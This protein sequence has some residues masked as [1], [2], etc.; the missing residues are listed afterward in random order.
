[1][2]PCAKIG[3]YFERCKQYNKKVAPL[4][5]AEAQ[6]IEFNSNIYFRPFVIPEQIDGMPGVSE[7]YAAH[8]V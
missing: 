6:D 8:L 4:L 5:E 1:M 3:F 2:F 7:Q